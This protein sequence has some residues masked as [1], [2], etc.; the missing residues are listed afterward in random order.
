[1][2]GVTIGLRDVHY[3]LLT[4][5][6]TGVGGI[7]YSLPAKIAGAI[8][9]DINPNA[10]NETLFADDGP[11]ETASSLGQISLDLTV[12][13]LPLEVQAALLGHSIVAGVLLRKSSDIPPW[14]AIGFKS[15]K[16][17]G[18]YRYVWLVKGKFST[19]EQKGATKGDKIAFQ[20]PSIKGNFVKRDGDDL[21]QKT[22]DEDAVGFVE[23]TATSWFTAT[24]PV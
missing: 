13:D 8:T 3:A 22:T 19:P 6:A 15:L 12:A 21:W 23:A 5:D 17:N 2:D 4:A 11:M 9:A 10:S 16:S 20:T 24:G 18:N 7:V 1:M 14:V